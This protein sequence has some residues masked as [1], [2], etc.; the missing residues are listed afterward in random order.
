MDDPLPAW[1]YMR[2]ADFERIYRPPKNLTRGYLHRSLIRAL[3]SVTEVVP[4]EEAILAKP[5]T[6]EL[7]GSLPPRLRL[8]AYA[9]TQHSSER[10]QGT[11]KAQLTG[12]MPSDVPGRYVF[13]RSGGV[14]PMLVGYHPDLAVFVLWDADLHDQGAGFPFSKSVQ[15]PPSIVWAAAARGIAS[16]TRQLRSAGEESIVAARADYMVKAVQTRI[17]LSNDSLLEAM[18]HA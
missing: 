4:T 3:R 9:A 2:D 14:R 17:R 11:F 16:T 8:Y 5:L 10:Q 7:S 6:L 18:A 13:D 1:L 15:A 12:G